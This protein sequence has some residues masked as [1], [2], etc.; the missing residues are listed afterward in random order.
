MLHYSWLLKS[1]M[2]KLISLA[3]IFGLFLGSCRIY[4]ASSNSFE[5]PVCKPPC[6]ENITPGITTKEEAARILSQLDVDQEPTELK[7][8]NSSADSHIPF[9]TRAID[10]S[11]VFIDDKVSIIS[12]SP[13]NDLSLQNAIE[14]FGKPQSVL[15]Y[16]GGEYIGVTFFK[17]QEGIVFRYTSWKQSRLLPWSQAPQWMYSEIR[18]EAE[19]NFITYF[20]PEQ[21]D[22]VLDYGILS[23]HELSPAETLQ[24]LYPWRGYGNIEQYL[25]SSEP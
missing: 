20:D 1:S 3:L 10:G 4:Q 17:P 14:I 9:S 5:N 23:F 12:L 16:R 15:V 2:L 8:V 11:L 6:W 19:I 7:L 21:P 22:S 13:K 18:P 24:R 25:P